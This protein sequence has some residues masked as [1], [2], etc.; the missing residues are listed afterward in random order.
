[1]RSEG[2]EVELR[3]ALSDFLLNRMS[4]DDLLGWEAEWSLRDLGALNRSRLD[5]IALVAT[6]VADGVRGEA[7]LRQLLADLLVS[8]NDASERFVA[9]TST[10]AGRFREIDGAPIPLF[11]TGTT[12]PTAVGI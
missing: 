7:E 4:V 9:A 3:Q 5:S 2:F 6:E 11:K 10:L 1:M 12:A 8:V